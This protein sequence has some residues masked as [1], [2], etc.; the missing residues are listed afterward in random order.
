MRDKEAMCKVKE[1]GYEFKKLAQHIYSLERR[2]CQ[3]IRDFAKKKKNKKINK[4][5]SQINKR[6]NN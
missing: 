6:G 3:A 4:K 1:M 2:H 5:R